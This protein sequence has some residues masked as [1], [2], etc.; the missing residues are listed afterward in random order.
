METAALKTIL[1]EKGLVLAESI[2]RLKNN[3]QSSFFPFSLFF[4]GNIVAYV[5]PILLLKTEG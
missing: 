2:L 3:T 1:V 5:N 4:F